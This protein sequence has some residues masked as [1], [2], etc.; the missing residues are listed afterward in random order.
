MSKCTKK[1]EYLVS[2]AGKQVKACEEHAKQLTM[3][4]NVIG[5]PVQ[6][7]QVKME[8]ECTMQNQ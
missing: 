3:L 4:G 1:A 2:W 8:D 5:S 6:V 7:A